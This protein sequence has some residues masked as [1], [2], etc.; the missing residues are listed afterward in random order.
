[1]ITGEYVH[2]YLDLS[3]AHIKQET[4]EW[5]EQQA[6]FQPQTAVAPPPLVVFQYKEGFFIP[7]PD[8]L[9][10]SIPQELRALLAVT[11]IAGA[12]LLRLDR[13]APAA[14]GLPVFDW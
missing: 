9:V 8:E 2:K 5:L 1:M 7:L 14:E 4:A 13:D 6:N 10:G 12:I 3:T 11:R